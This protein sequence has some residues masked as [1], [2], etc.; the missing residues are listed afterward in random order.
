MSANGN[1]DNKGPSLEK[2]NK[3]IENHSY[4]AM[5]LYYKNE[6]K[7]NNSKT[8]LKEIYIWIFLINNMRW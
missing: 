1:N 3:L 8:N 5:I 6:L 4:S 7:I 2:E